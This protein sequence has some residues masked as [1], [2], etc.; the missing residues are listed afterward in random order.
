VIQP[1]SGWLLP[2][3]AA[4]WADALGGLEAAEVARRGTGARA[5]FEAKFDQ[6]V[7]TRQLLDTYDEVVAQ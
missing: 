4:V 2:A 7:T 6:R 5:A 3:D 1:E